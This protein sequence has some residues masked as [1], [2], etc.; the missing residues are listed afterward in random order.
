LQPRLHTDVGYFWEEDGKYLNLTY[1][2][3]EKAHAEA[4]SKTRGPAMRKPKKR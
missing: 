3:Y 1:E 2:E 4:V